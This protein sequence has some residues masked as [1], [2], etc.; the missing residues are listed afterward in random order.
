[1]TITI[2]K[3]RI[4]IAILLGILLWAAIIYFLLLGDAYKVAQTYV[5]NYPAIKDQVGEVKDVEVSIFQSSIHVDGSRGN[6]DYV[7]TVHGD[8]GKAKV[9]VVMEKKADQWSVSDLRVK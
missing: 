1:M 6:A 4:I 8:K 9:I 7:L 5:M 3:K 2:N